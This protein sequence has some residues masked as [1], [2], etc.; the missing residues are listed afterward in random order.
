[1]VDCL[2]KPTTTLF[3]ALCQSKQSLTKSGRG[4]K[5]DF[6]LNSDPA[7]LFCVRNVYSKFICPLL[8]WIHLPEYIHQA[9]FFTILPQNIH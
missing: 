7:Y 6:Q 9:S 4:W 2:G 3:M 8:N 5:E 1:M